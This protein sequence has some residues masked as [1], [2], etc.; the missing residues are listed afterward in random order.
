[1]I[2][3]TGG[4]GLIE[5][6]RQ[7]LLARRAVHARRR[8][9]GGGL[10]PAAGDDIVAVVEQGDHGASHTTLMPECQPSLRTDA[11][12]VTAHFWVR[13]SWKMFCWPAF[14]AK[15]AAIFSTSMIVSDRIVK[16]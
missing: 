9:V 10:R 15:K 3:V 12:S 11:P 1:M 4:A 7:R 13:A 16:A 8:G 2:I 14:A 6:H 5:H